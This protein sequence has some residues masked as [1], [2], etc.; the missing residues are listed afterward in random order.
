[1]CYNRRMERLKKIIADAVEFV[2]AAIE[3]W[4]K[5]L[6]PEGP[7]TSDTGFSD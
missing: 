1:M 6:P 2:L 7:G 3:T 4:W 5:S